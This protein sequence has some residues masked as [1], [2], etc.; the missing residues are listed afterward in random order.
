M[1][2][3]QVNYG[4]YL[5]TDE[6]SMEQRDFLET[7][8]KALAGGV[9]LVQLREKECSSREFYL[10]GKELHQLTKAYNVPLIINDR[11]DLALAIGAEGVHLG[12]KDLPVSVARKLAG[13]D[14]IIG[15]SAAT[16]EEAVAAEK[17]GADYLGVGALYPTGTK[18]D[19]RPVSCETL[20]EIVRTVSIPVVAIGGITRERLQEVLDSG[21]HGVAV[22]SAILKADSPEE[23]AIE[24]KQIIHQRKER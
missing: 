20:E 10:R 18:T 2:K 17:Q 13:D 7:V 21:V 14:M 19:T 12:Q 4:L 8:E 1:N 3:K 5:V 24:F 22:V 15:V 16:L 11:I 23:S 9:T 6:N